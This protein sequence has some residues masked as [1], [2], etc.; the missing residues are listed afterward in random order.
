MRS[1]NSFRH[2][3]FTTVHVAVCA[4]KAMLYYV[5]I[6]GGLDRRE[7]NAESSAGSRVQKAFAGLNTCTLMQLATRHSLRACVTTIVQY[8][9]QSP[10]L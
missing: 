10:V 8:L 3:A 7:G 9:Q 4:D 6:A 1:S 5:H 2:C